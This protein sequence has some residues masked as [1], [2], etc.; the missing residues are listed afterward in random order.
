MKKR[1]LSILLSFTLVLSLLSTVALAEGNGSLDDSADIT[2]YN[3]NESSF[4]IETAA[5]LA[6]L[7]QI[8]NGTGEVQDSFVGKTIT[9]ANPIDLDLKEWTPIGTSAA[10]FQG[11]FN[12][13]NH[14]ISNLCIS[15]TDNNQG[16][17][18]STN[19]NQGL[20]GCIQD[21]IICN[22]TLNS[23]LIC[24]DTNVG[25]IAGEAVNSTITNC[26][27]NS[28]KPIENYG[29]GIRG[30]ESVGG[31]VGCSQDSHVQNCENN[32]Y[33][34]LLISGSDPARYKL[35]GIAGVAT[36]SAK[37]CSQDDAVL[38]NDCTNNGTIT[39]TTEAN[40]ECTGG[41]VGR[42]V[43]DNADY[44][45]IVK[46]CKNTGVVSSIEAGT[47][48]I[49]GYAQ[50]ASIETCENENTIT[51]TIG[52]GGIAGYA[53]YGTQILSCTNS[54]SVTGNPYSSNDTTVYPCN[55]GGIVGSI[56]NPRD[57]THVEGDCDSLP[58]YSYNKDSLISDCINS[59][60]V[61]CSFQ[62]SEAEPTVRLVDGV[63]YA[64]NV[65][66]SFVGGI[67]GF[68]VDSAYF[69]EEGNV[70]RIEKCENSGTVTGT[71]YVG[72]VLGTGKNADVTD[73]TNSGNITDADTSESDTIRA[74]IGGY[75][76]TVR[77]DANGGAV[78]AEDTL[79]IAVY[80]VLDDLPTPIRSGNYRFDGWFTEKTG[81]TKITAEMVYEEN[82]TLYAHWSY[83]GNHSDFSAPTYSITT[84]KTENGTINVSH[85]YAKRG[86]TV[87]ITVGPDT[88]WTLKTL[89]VTDR[90]G[91]ELDLTIVEAGEKYRFK[92][93]SG[94]VEVKATFMEDNTMLNYFVD[95]NAQ[96]YFYDAVL[97]AAEKGITSGTDDSH[98]SPN[99]PC[100]R[101]QIV[102]FLWRA[103][104]SPAVNYAMTMEDVPADAY[105]TEAI[106]W[107]LSEGIT[108]GTSETTFSPND[109][110]TR[111][112][113]L[114]FLYRAS[115]SPAVSGSGTEFSDV[116]DGAYYANAVKWAATEGVT[117]GTGS[118]TFSPDNNC[119]RA[120]IVTF[121]WRA[122]AE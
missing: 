76:Y 56:Y 74:D 111:A 62:W 91:K 14:S 17:I 12:G 13:D 51:G 34:Y 50:N 64:I 82:T 11:K 59:G 97:W 49:V 21:A 2:W 112:Q 115:G 60:T 114:T 43:S 33:V 5:E 83:I 103:A 70:V 3:T 73:C 35:G 42:L 88:G 68:A 61:T 22:V 96:H 120:Q 110:C 108:K 29:W 52:V 63:P 1:L 27:V 20:F 15:S 81:G 48:G 99:S 10:P 72:G 113:A 30:S 38:I 118:D 6:G 98:F 105:Y 78:N 41:V 106:R 85:R 25:G 19:N 89:T 57:T 69:E 46:N 86:D 54:G 71:T 121:L 45:A 53:Y 95:V 80:G 102:T 55:I 122:M 39:C 37:A 104:G 23:V 66:G 101:A 116:A 4:S 67:A 75:S 84:L 28:D 18:S 47:G 40:Y 92:M 9:L 31:I 36:L 44:R 100:T 87:T 93:P 58:V 8:V 90:N 94:K 109:T 107:A 79:K 65:Y 117:E 24:G 7:A 26:T 77:F 32:A 119:T 16:L